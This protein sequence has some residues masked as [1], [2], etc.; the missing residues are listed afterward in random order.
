M[1]EPHRVPHRQLGRDDAAGGLKW[2][3]DLDANLDG[4]L[5]I[6]EAAP[7][8]MTLRPSAPTPALEPRNAHT[9]SS[10]LRQSV[11]D[12]RHVVLALSDEERVALDTHARP[13]P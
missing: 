13:G 6:G 1:P 8:N 9:S 10:S 5:D 7:V 11:G 4:D 3:A 2:F 12:S